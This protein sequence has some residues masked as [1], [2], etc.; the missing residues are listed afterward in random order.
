MYLSKKSV[1]SWVSSLEASCI[2]D[3]EDGNSNVELISFE[4]EVILE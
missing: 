1:K 2:P 3:I 4:T